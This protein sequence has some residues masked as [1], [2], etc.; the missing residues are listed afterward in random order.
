MHAQD[1]PLGQ[2]AGSNASPNGGIL[3]MTGSNQNNA[4]NGFIMSVPGR[5]L[6]A[7]PPGGNA[8]GAFNK[9][10]VEAYIAYNPAVRFNAGGDANNNL[11]FPAFWCWTVEGLNEYSGAIP[12]HTATSTE[13]DFLEEQSGVFG[14]GLTVPFHGGSFPG[15]FGTG[16]TTFAQANYPLANTA[17]HTFG[18]LW[19]QSNNVTFYRDGV[20][21]G[22]AFQMAGVNSAWPNQHIFITL[23]TGYQWPMY[24]DWVRAWGT[25]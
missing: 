5:G 2:G 12:F 16:S 3:I 20:Q 21:S 22:T 19:D 24:V 13:I 9:V 23:G 15:G 4:G 1:I 11:W 14:R 18:F 8:Q 6:T 25:P 10:Y 7:I 17:W